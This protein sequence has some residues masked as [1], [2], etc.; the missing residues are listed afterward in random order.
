[1]LVTSSFVGLIVQIFFT[2]TWTQGCV[3]PQAQNVMRLLGFCSVLRT[4]R[5]SYVSGQALTFLEGLVVFL[6]VSD[7]QP[8]SVYTHRKPPWMGTS[9]EFGAALGLLPQVSPLFW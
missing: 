7:M 2:C 8:S 4:R 9:Q 6:C 5:S 1:M 3:Y